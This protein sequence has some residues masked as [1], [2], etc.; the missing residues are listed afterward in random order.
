MTKTIDYA[1]TRKETPVGIIALWGPGLSEPLPILSVWFFNDALKMTNELL[2]SFSDAKFRCVNSKLLNCIGLWFL[3][4]ESGISTVS[5]ILS[6]THEVNGFK[7]L[8]EKFSGIP[9]IMG[10]NVL[11]SSVQIAEIQEFCCF[12]NATFH[13]LYYETKNTQYAKTHFSKIP[14][15]ANEIDM[16]EAIRISI[17]SLNFYRYAIQG[18]SLIENSRNIINVYQEQI[19]PKFHEIMKQRQYH[20]ISFRDI[21]TEISPPLTPNIYNGVIKY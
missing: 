13:D 20:S 15:Y 21:D 16:I 2:D 18:V 4:M 10:S 19:L 3:A 12:R 1:E 5:K 11:P 17:N 9:K 8:P 7:N 6:L 14:A